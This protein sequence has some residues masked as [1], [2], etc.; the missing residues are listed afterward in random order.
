LTRRR[1]T[2]RI[3]RQLVERCGDIL[4]AVQTGRFA[5]EELRPVLEEGGRRHRTGSGF[6]AAR[7]QFLGA[8]RDGLD[9]E[10]AATAIAA[11]ADF[12]VAIVLAEDHGM[13][14]DAVEAWI[15]DAIAR[16]VLKP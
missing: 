8:L 7:L 2:A 9:F 14:F 5:E 1:S 15:A 11:L 12:R 4:R 3:T 16:V 6:V 13:S 10:A